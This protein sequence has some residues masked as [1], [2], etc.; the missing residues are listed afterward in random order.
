MTP[1]VIVTMTK[2][3]VEGAQCQCCAILLV[4]G[5]KLL[6]VKLMTLMT[7]WMVSRPAILILKMP[8]VLSPPRA[9]PLPA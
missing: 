4:E 8:T 7:A 2:I 1:L 6:S 9:S 3:P 5:A